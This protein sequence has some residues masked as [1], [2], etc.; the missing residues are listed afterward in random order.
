MTDD[1]NIPK[2]YPTLGNDQTHVKAEKKSFSL[3]KASDI[4]RRTDNVSEYYKGEK[5]L[6]SLD[7]P[8]IHRREITHLRSTDEA[9]HDEQYEAP[10]KKVSSDSE[11]F[12]RSEERRVGK[13]RR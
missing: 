3:P 1:T 7:T 2:I 8:A 4:A 9:D 6:K 13:E 11:G 10:H 5:N 12:S